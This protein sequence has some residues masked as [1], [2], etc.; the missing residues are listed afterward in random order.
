MVESAAGIYWVGT[1]DAIKGPAAHKIAATTKI[2][3]THPKYQQAQG[4]EC[5]LSETIATL[6]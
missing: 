3:H 4:W 5:P 2:L 6:G 1:N